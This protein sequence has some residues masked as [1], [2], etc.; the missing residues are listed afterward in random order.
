MKN[1]KSRSLLMTSLSNKELENHSIYRYNLLSACT[2]EG[3][4]E[5]DLETNIAYYNNGMRDLFGFS[6]EEMSNNDKW[7]N[8]NVHP[9]DRRRIGGSMETFLEGKENVWWGR[10]K[11]R[12]KQGS[13]KEVLD[14]LFVVRNKDKKP[15]RLIGTMQDLTEVNAMQAELDDFKLAHKKSMFLARFNAREKEK[16]SIS[17]ELNENINQ[18]L[19]GINMYINEATIHTD[20]SGTEKLKEAKVLLLESINGVRSIAER[21][22][23]PMLQ[24]LGLKEALQCLLASTLETKSIICNLQIDEEI[25]ATENSS[26]TILYFRIVQQQINNIL[27]HSNAS[28]VNICIAKENNKITV[29]IVD[30]GDGVDSRELTYGEGF[31]NFQQI[32]DSFDGSFTVQSIAG[33]AGFTLELKL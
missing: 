3:I 23:P 2:R 4:W 25:L 13:Y 26:N 8:A 27:A 19:A 10:Y 21:L 6:L 1:I 9:E 18:A 15:I 17:D 12:C 31:S 16:K 32:T 33:E 7:W 30:N 14:R 11:F 20:A 29:S 5:L 22:S 28:I 24:I